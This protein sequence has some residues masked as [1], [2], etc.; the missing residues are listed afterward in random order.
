MTY[1]RIQTFDHPLWSIGSGEQ[2]TAELLFGAAALAALVYCVRVSLRRGQKWPLFVFGGAALT[3][4]YEPLNNLLGHCAYPEVGQHTYIDMFGR[5]IP[6]FIGFVYMFYFAAPVTWLM[7]RYEAGI[8]ARRLAKYYAVGVVLCAAFEPV[9]CN[10][11]IGLKWWHYY[12]D[13]QALAFTGLPM[14][15]WFV[16]PM[17]VFANAYVFHLLRKHVLTS[18]AQTALFVP[19]G[20][21]CVIA[22]HLTAGLP[23]YITI[24]GTDG[25]TLTTLATFGSIAIAGMYMWIIG[26]TVTVPEAA[27]AA[28]RAPDGRRVAPRPEPL[29][30]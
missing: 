26:R 7:Q 12:G 15:W 6:L 8:S 19:L 17:C 22:W 24:I 9:F 1:D 2:L 28:E 20:L 11:D 5:Q 4:V 30:V 27:P 21:L 13:N 18:D 14:W 10:G 3:V 16:N 25:K 23:M 29:G